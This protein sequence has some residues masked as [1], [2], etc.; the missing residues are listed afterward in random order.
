M[1]QKN[2]QIKCDA[3]LIKEADAVFKSMGLKTTVAV[4]LF[5]QQ[6]VNLKAFPFELKGK[7]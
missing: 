3:K 6:C 4:R 5:L 2:L 7:K 1:K